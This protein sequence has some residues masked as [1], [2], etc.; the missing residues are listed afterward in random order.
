MKYLEQG[1]VLLLLRRNRS[2][3]QWFQ[4]DIYHAQDQIRQDMIEG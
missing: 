4:A 1:L 3:L 2:Q